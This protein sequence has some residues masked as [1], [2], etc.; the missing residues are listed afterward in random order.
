MS[1]YQREG[2]E[3]GQRKKKE[4]QV[5]QVRPGQGWGRGCEAATT[6]YLAGGE[7]KGQQILRMEQSDIQ[8]EVT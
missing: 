1:S 3:E 6:T 7:G 4:N 8:F 5:T 2:G